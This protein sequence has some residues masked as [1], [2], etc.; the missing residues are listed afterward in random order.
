MSESASRFSNKPLIHPTQDEMTPKNSRLSEPTSWTEQ[1]KK[2]LS[3]KPAELVNSSGSRSVNSDLAETFRHSGWAPFRKRVDAALEQCD[4]VSS[5]RLSAFRCCG[6]DAHVESRIAGGKFSLGGGPPGMTI[7]RIRST[8]CHDRFCLPCSKAR[9]ERIRT[10]LAIWLKP[11]QNL[12]LITLTLKQGPAT[13]RSTLDRIT[14][15]FRCLRGK[16]L[17]KKCV[18]GG[19]ATIE[20]KIGDD[21]NKFKKED[22][23]WNVHFHIIA[24]AK[25]IHQKSLSKLWL[26][27]T[28]D[29]DIVDV[30]RVGARSGAIQYITKYIT[31]SSDHQIVNSPRHLDEAI[32]AF[33]GRR[34]VTTFATWRG[35]K[36]ME[37]HDDIETEEEKAGWHAIGPLDDFIRRAAR[38]D[39]EALAVMRKLIPPKQLAEPRPPDPGDDSTP[40]CDSTK[41]AFES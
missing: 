39:V 25:Y 1:T 38:G 16:K 30:R 28:G 31:K 19:V 17:W 7:Y 23:P 37:I 9:A 36:L 20:A 21:K 41:G 11:K 6:S 27:I 29:S 14:R 22:K 32:N 10:S 35:L 15:A 2:F 33:T 3:E 13:L 24:E 4:K 26:E 12:S 18:L 34:L 40:F 8:K 5:R